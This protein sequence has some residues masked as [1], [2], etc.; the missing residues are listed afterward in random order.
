MTTEIAIMNKSAVVLAA[1]SAVTVSDVSSHKTFHTSRKLFSLRKGCPV[2]VMVYGNSEIMGAPWE[3]IIKA[4]AKD[5]ESKPRPTLRDYAKAFF[6]FIERFPFDPRLGDIKGTDI[7]FYF[8][9]K[10]KAEIKE[11]NLNKNN[12]ADLLNKQ[13]HEQRLALQ[14]LTGMSGNAESAFRKAFLQT[15]HETTDNLFK[16][17]NLHNS[18]KERLADVSMEALL[19]NVFSPHSSSIVFAG[20]GEN[21]YFPR[22]IEYKIDGVILHFARRVACRSIEIVPHDALTDG[23]QTAVEAASDAS[24]DGCRKEKLTSDIIAF[25]N[26]SSVNGF[27]GGANVNY[28]TMVN[29]N[30]HNFVVKILLNIIDKYFTVEMASSKDLYK[31][32]SDMVATETRHFER[33]QIDYQVKNFFGPVRDAIDRMPNEELAYIAESLVSLTSLRQKLNSNPE[34]AGGPIDVAVISKGD[35]FIWLKR[36]QYFD[37]DLNYDV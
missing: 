25:A 4:F 35:G 20:F 21:E 28:Q 22:L 7:I 36:K 17:Y 34:T 16:E 9:S 14:R 13:I 37:S 5:G 2:G 30:F 19:G 29:I 24:L 1:D 18:F 26:R 10:L 27:L 33:D 32:I 11:L 31:Y 12:F 23:E 6:T 8:L 3:T 15:I